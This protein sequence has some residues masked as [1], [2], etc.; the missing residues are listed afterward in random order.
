MYRF[1]MY[2]IIPHYKGFLL[3]SYKLYIKS[4]YTISGEPF[5]VLYVFQSK[6]LYVLR[7]ISFY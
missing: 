7:F 2:I 6:Y 1:Y 3:W 4:Y 5:R